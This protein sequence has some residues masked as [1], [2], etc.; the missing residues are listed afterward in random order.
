MSTPQYDVIIVGARPAGAVTALL[1]AR[2]GLRVL[3]L[4]RARYGSDTVSTHALMRGGVYLLQQWG[5]LDDIVAAGTPPVTKVVFH[6]PGESTPISLKPAAGVPALYAPRRT[7]LDPALADAA[8]RAGAELWYET[9]VTGLLRDDAGRVTG[10]E[11]RDRAG[12]RALLTATLTVG[13]DGVGSRVAG[14]VGAPTVRTATGTGTGVLYGYWQDLPAEGYEWVYAP[15]A[16]AGLIPTNDGRTLVFAG[17]TPAR[18][19][20][21]RAEGTWSAFDRV[22]GQASPAIRDRVAAARAPGHLRGF[23][24]MPGYVRRSWGPGWALVGD[25]GYFEDPLSTHGITDALR[26]AALLADAVV[27]IHS[28][29]ASEAGALAAYQRQRDT[30]SEPLFRAIDEVSSYRWTMPE[31]RRLLLT[32]SSAMTAQVETLQ[33]LVPAP[34]AAPAVTA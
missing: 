12:H 29:D 22:L 33:E 8:T 14:E 13:A 6:Y 34:A 7:V 1:L 17:A 9:S 28:G 27:K 4:D 24:G 11:T 18:I 21:A 15:N 3:A 30:M 10:V 26:D 2:R 25:A 5:I 20:A 16:S 31:L 32:A 19:K 23:A